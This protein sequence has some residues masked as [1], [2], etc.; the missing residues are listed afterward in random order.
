[1]GFRTIN[2]RFYRIVPQDRAAQALS[3]AISPEG[4]FHHDNQPTLYVSP[5]A[6]WAEHAIKVY[7]RDDDPRRIICELEIKNAQVLDLRDE[8]HCA[9]WG[10]D[11]ALGSIPW[12]P[13]RSRGLAAST[14]KLSDFART[15]GADGMIY[16]ARSD[17][18]R[19]HMALFDWRNARVTGKVFDY[20]LGSAQ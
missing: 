13:E 15:I 18:S 5:R 7:V 9:F 8:E 14:W 16:T 3:P 2:G 10:V 17:P 6:D 1:M 19:W 20:P 11:A 4:R 12:L